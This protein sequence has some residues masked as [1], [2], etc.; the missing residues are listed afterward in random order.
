MNKKSPAYVLSC[1]AAIC[2]VFGAGISA[3][4]YATQGLLLKNAAKHRNRVLCNAFLL[5]VAGTSAEA[6]QQAVDASLRTNLLGGRLVYTCVAPGKES[7][8]FVASGMGFWDRIECVVVLSPDLDRILNLQV[9]GQLETPGLGARIEE[10]A[11]TGQFQGRL[12]DWSDA[13]GNRIVVGASPAPNA[14]NRV[15]AITG[16]TQT[17]MALMRFLN[18]ELDLFRKQYAEGRP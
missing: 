18:D 5:D 7:V 11:F 17:S 4:N 10:P 1:M 3:V 6:Y 15:D 16:A 8:G 12:L 14:Q 2:I 9:L 13:Q